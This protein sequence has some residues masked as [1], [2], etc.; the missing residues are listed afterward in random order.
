MSA[1]DFSKF[2]KIAEDDKTVTMAHENGHSMRIIKSAIPK[3]QREQLKMLPLA[4]GGEIKGIST[5]GK[6]V[7]N[8]KKAKARGRDADAVMDLELAKE[9]ASGRAAHERMIKP[10]MK[11]LA[12]GGDPKVA[13]EADPNQAPA[14]PPVTVNVNA[15]PQPQAGQAI[16]QPIQAAPPMQ[17]PIPPVP[18]PQMPPPGPIT[19][20]GGIE[21]QSGNTLRGLQQGQEGIQAQQALES[22]LAKGQVPIAEQETAGQQERARVVAQAYNHFQQ[23]G[24]AAIQKMASGEVDP[25]RFWNNTS[26]G[27]KIGTTIGLMLGGFGVPFGG[28]NFAYDKLQADIT[29]DVEAQKENAHIRNNVWSAYKDLYGYTPVA[30]QLAKAT[31][32]DAAAAQTKV[33][34]LKLGD[35]ASR[36]RALKAIGDFTNASEQARK[37]ASSIYGEL[38]GSMPLSQNQATES[39]GA[40]PQ[41]QGAPQ[42]QPSEA[43]QMTPAEMSAANAA[44]LAGA[45][46]KEDRT[47]SLK[48]LPNDTVLSPGHERRMV[49]AK[50]GFFKDRYP[51]VAKQYDAAVQTDKMLGQLNKR[52]LDMA[53]LA[54]KGGISGYIHRKVDPHA[55]AAGIGTLGG[56]AGT[57]VPAL[58][59]IAGGAVG[60]IGGEA[61]GHA[62]KQA[63][64]G[65][66]NT[67]YDAM[68]ASLLQDVSNALRGTDVNSTQIEAAVNAFAPD[69]RD[70]KQGRIEKLQGLRQFMINA[71]RTSELKLAHVVK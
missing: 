19:A 33:Q 9:E 16:Q 64:A 2:K 71:A 38:H 3:L 48:D 11:G 60:G 13:P 57:I 1:F 53:D 58:G 55:L 26:T 44:K 36:S 27:E 56:V 18:V 5:Q 21:N 67:R 17:G 8:A 46:P 47:L 25:K 51:D 62:I 61:I 69:I 52:Y 10:K 6:D 7:R 23:T 54:D 39:P 70:S 66:I 22:A 4:K 31:L 40:P 28:R 43:K 59:T 41:P 42:A 24:E 14:Q 34:A 29:R 49:A 63:T 12:D 20:E 65:D 45:T 50:E 32:L 37:S 15:Q 30:D 35:L 68:K